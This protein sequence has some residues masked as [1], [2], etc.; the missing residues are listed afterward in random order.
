MTAY[1]GLPI[2]GVFSI[3]FIMFLHMLMCC[4]MSASGFWA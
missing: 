4:F 3:M 1:F 2:P